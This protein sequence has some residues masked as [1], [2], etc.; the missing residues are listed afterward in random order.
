M[1]PRRQIAFH[2]PHTMIFYHGRKELG[3]LLGPY[4]ST[5]IRHAD[6]ISMFPAETGEQSQSLAEKVKKL[7]SKRPR[8]I[9]K[10]SG[11]LFAKG[12]DPTARFFDLQGEIKEQVKA[13]N[14]GRWIQIG[15]W[16][17]LMYKN[18]ESLI[19]IERSF[20]DYVGFDSLFC[21]YRV[22][23]FCS[24]HPK[25]VAQLVEVH[26]RFVFRTSLPETRLMSSSYTSN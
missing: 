8:L 11:E 1:A 6:V 26:D 13:R 14:Y 3:E 15:D 23:G 20:T 10:N 17:H 7:A 21:C 12:V 9:I 25:H 22:E 4:F 19:K 16:P 5:G 2:F 18:V 24:L